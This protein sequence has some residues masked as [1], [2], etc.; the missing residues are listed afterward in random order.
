MASSASLEKRVLDGMKTSQK[1][2]ELNGEPGQMS[3]TK[4]LPEYLKQK[5]RA[6]GILKDNKNAGYPSESENVSK[7]CCLWNWA[8]KQN[9]YINSYCF[10]FQDNMSLL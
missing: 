10:F 7:L 8:S 3:A 2:A 9:P 1:N 6:R 5:L 4:D